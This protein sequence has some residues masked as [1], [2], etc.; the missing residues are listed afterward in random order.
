MFKLKVRYPYLLVFN[1]IFLVEL[2]SFLAYFLPALQ[3]YLIA[4][5]FIIL[6][7]LSVYYLEIGVLVALSEL[8]IGSKGHLLSANFFGLQLSLRLVIWLALMIATLVIILKDEGLKAY[9]NRFKSYPFYKLFLIFVVFIVIGGV[10]AYLSGNQPNLIFNDI[11]AWFYLAW[12]LPLSLVYFPKIEKDKLIKLAKIFSIAILWLSLKTLILL[13]FFS[14]NSAIVPDLYLWVRRSG[15]G[16]ITAMGG[17]WYRIFIQSQVYIIIAFFLTLFIFLKHSFKSHGEKLKYLG[18][19]AVLMSIIII[20][21]SRSF[22]LALVCSGLLA[23]MFFWRFK[24][25]LY[26]K[27]GIYTLFSIITA[28]I[29]IF[30]IIKFPYP[31]HRESVSMNALSERL[32][33]KEDEAALASRWALLPALWK[34]IVERPILGSGFGKTVG[35]F[36]QDPRVLEN[37]PDGLY[38]TYAFEWAYLDTWLKIGLLGL[39]SF[40]SYLLLLLYRLWQESRRNN[41]DIYAALAASLLFLLIVNIFTPYL[42]HPLGLAFVLI[43]SCFI[44]KNP[45]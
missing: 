27:A 19:L 39:I 37:N 21:M 3:S 36:S 44:K 29:L 28:L 32:E 10:N 14:H 11:N 2:L 31:A 45:I 1:L 15:V 5:I 42:N 12:L 43:S 22:W 4:L 9:V 17:G 33:F 41:N 23:A 35:Y 16:E 6:I 24:W 34:G 18:V 30:I 26:L 40:L 13:F 25:R 20:S 38:E 8:V 7:P